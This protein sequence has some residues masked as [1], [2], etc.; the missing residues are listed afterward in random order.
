MD[1]LVNANNEFALDLYNRFCGDGENV[2]FSPYS[3][4]TALGMALEGAAALHADTT[5]WLK[6]RNYAIA[7]TEHIKITVAGQASWDTILDAGTDGPAEAIFNIDL[8]KD[9][10]NAPIIVATG[11]AIT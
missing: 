11:V 5:I 6:R 9:G 4:T 8:A 1:D 2:F 3:I 10:A 7:A